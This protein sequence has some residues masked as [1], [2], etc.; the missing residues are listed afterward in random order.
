MKNVV[1]VL[2]GCVLAIQFPLSMLGWACA[3]TVYIFV[4]SIR[5][6]PVDGLV[7]LRRPLGFATLAAAHF[8]FGLLLVVM[9][10]MPLERYIIALSPL[11]PGAILLLTLTVI[12]ELIRRPAFPGNAKQ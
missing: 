4:R 8:L 10:E 6:T 11:L 12:L 3:L 5:N 7:R 1:G 9:V 2:R